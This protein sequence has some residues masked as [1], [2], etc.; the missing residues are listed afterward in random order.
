MSWWR[1]KRKTELQRQREFLQTVM[2]SVTYDPNFELKLEPP[3]PNRMVDQTVGRT[4]DQIAVIIGGAEPR[5][6]TSISTLV[7]P[8]D[9][10]RRS[11]G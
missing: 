11:T 8:K 2:R 1:R 5:S 10:L 9:K 3:N 4:L 6:L 7:G